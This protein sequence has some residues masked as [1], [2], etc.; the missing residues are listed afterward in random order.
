V[1]CVLLLSHCLI[2]IGFKSFAVCYVLIIYFIFLCVLFSCIVLC[3]VSA[4]VESRLFSIGVQFYR[5]L[6]PGGNS[7]AVNKYRCRRRH[8]HHHHH[9]MQNFTL[10]IQSRKFV[11]LRASVTNVLQIISTEFNPYPANVENMVST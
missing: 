9:V 8:Y 11:E 7:F 10:V 2:L 4:H 6:P 3:T 1:Q 5:P